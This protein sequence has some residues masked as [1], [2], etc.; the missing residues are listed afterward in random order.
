[1]SAG[2]IFDY[3]KWDK[4]ELSDDES[5]LHP[6]IDKDSWFRLKHRTRLEREEKEDKEIKGY[7][8]LNKAD[9]GRINIISRRLHGAASSAA[10][11]DAQFED[12]ESLQ[13][14]LQELNEHISQRNERIQSINERRKWNIDNICTVK[15]E[16]TLVSS[17]DS[18]S[19]SASDFKPSGATAAMIKTDN[20]KSTSSASEPM[21]SQSSSMATKTSST[22]T[23][24]PVATT[25]PARSDSPSRERFAVI[26][27][28]DYA[29]MH[30]NVLETYSDIK[31]FED[32]KDFLFKHCDVLL[33]EHAQSYMLLSCLEDEMNGKRT[34]MKLVCRQSQILSHIQELGNSMRRDPRDVILPFFRRISEKEYLQAFVAA[35][36]D[37]IGKIVK[38]AVEKR[39]EM[40]EDAKRN[41][42]KGPA[43][44]DP[45][46]VLESLPE[47]L[48][49]AFESQNIEALHQAL[50][51]MNP[52]EAKMYMKQCVDSGLWVP[53]DNSVFRDDDQEDEQGV[54]DIDDSSTNN[55]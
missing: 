14:E 7:E 42:P 18:A 48:K 22:A 5:D 36:D 23:I 4:I 31:D 43:G 24:S 9:Q 34:R 55:I 44:L 26:S 35:V 30:E 33:H 38:R 2:K 16:K 17:T 46:E 37:F 13:E 25:G 32:S 54:D 53:A 27:Y 8:I 21:K 11:E 29:I 19:L 50:A 10:D 12:L 3:S 40:D 52:V 20:S 49:T 45:Y 39:K 28:N 15:D 51:E 1:M 6:N 41:V 47:V